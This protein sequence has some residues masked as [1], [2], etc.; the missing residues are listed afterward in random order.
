MNT[1][2]IN[3]RVLGIDYPVY[4]VADIGANHDGSL[5]RAYKL[6]ELAKESG[7]DAAKFQNFQAGKIVSDAGFK[8]LASQLSHQAGWKKTIYNVYEDASVSLDWTEKL[9]K[10]C[11]DIGIE[12][13]T[14]PY[15]YDSVDHV[16]PYVDLFKVGSG[17]ITWLEMIEY[18]AKKGKPILL[19]TGAASMSDVQRAME[20]ATK[21]TKDVVLMQ[22]NT[23]YTGSIENFDFINLNVLNTFKEKYPGVI[24]GL[25][26]HT[27][28][29][30]TVLGAIALGA[31]VIEKHFTDDN[32]REGPDHKFAM[33]PS[34]WREMVD[35]S[36]ELF[37][38]MGDGIKRVEEN[39]QKSKIVQ[40]RSIRVVREM[41]IGEEISLQDVE[42]LRPIPPDGFPPYMINDIIGK[43]V[44][45]P[46]SVGEHVTSINV[47]I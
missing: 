39:E 38:S 45:N 1:I 18:I 21:V 31:R 9:K 2:Q 36:N 14:S 7:A 20:V 32:E 25:S 40:Q 23:N 42:Y 22:C 30:A 26:D 43:K 41:E 44:I 46:I 11:D 24:L 37:R 12:Y 34:T 15:D 19:A 13:F 8:N 4:F 17:D 28:G 3:G 47:S 6:I 29:H 35:R 27:S 5:E 33:N 16:D 10:K